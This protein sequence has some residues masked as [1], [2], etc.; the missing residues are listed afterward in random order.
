[1]KLI[2]WW[3]SLLT[4]LPLLYLAW[5]KKGWRLILGVIIAATLI[6]SYFIPE[7]IISSLTHKEITK[8]VNSKTKKIDELIHNASKQETNSENHQAK[9]EEAKLIVK[10]EEEEKELKNQF[11]KLIREEGQESPNTQL[12]LKEWKEKIQSINFQKNHWISNWSKEIFSSTT[13]FC[14]E[15]F[16]R[17]LTNKEY[18]IEGEEVNISENTINFGDYQDKSTEEVRKKILEIIVKEEIKNRN[19]SV[20]FLK[21][22]NK[23]FKTKVNELLLTLFGPRANANLWKFKMKFREGSE[24]DWTP[25]LSKFLFI[26]S[27][28]K[29]DYK[30]S[31]ELNKNFRTVEVP[32]SKNQPAILSFL[33]GL[34]VIIFFFLIRSKRKSQYEKLQQ[35]D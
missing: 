22:I 5:W 34:E 10:W 29:S 8:E 17:I 16:N 3:L 1:M 19:F 7:E 6:A 20:I 31:E 11:E 14:G 27:S 15:E 26:A 21:N 12:K 28:S 24:M 30:N 13:L 2:I 25:N 32:F 4:I 18:K 33:F 35:L 23:I 9:V